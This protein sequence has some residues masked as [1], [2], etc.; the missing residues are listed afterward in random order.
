MINP[1]GKCADFLSKMLTVF[2]ISFNYVTD[3]KTDVLDYP[4]VIL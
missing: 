1:N 3:I 2:S 4:L